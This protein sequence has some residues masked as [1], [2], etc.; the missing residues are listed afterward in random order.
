MYWGA[1]SGGG[2]EHRG[3][4]ALPQEELGV[5]TLHPRSPH[6]PPSHTYTGPSIAQRKAA[7]TTTLRSHRSGLFFCLFSSEIL[8]LNQMVFDLLPPALRR[9]AQVPSMETALPPPRAIGR[10]R[11]GTRSLRQRPAPPA[12][13]AA[14]GGGA[15]RFPGRRDPAS[16]SAPIPH[17]PSVP[18]RWT[19][20]GAEGG[21]TPAGD[22]RRV[23]PLQCPGCPRIG[24]ASARFPRSPGRR[25]QFFATLPPRPQL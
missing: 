20:Q 23:A 8:L 4:L 3:I 14:R 25:A 6:S 24:S 11:A 17:A 10:G 2:R 5:R 21:R 15:L 7:T 22:S 9:R 18:V 1:L 19:G 16:R 12:P 13:R